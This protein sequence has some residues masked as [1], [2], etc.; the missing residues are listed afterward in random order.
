MFD[1]DIPIL[2]VESPFSLNGSHKSS[3]LRFLSRPLL[4]TRWAPLLLWPGTL[5][6]DAVARDAMARDAVDVLVSVLV[7]VAVATAAVG[8]R[9]QR[10]GVTAKWEDQRE[11]LQENRGYLQIWNFRSRFF[12]QTILRL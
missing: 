5:A 9:G 2:Y 11:I 7:S 8:P 4:L 1:G 3:I 10:H 12:L 6:A